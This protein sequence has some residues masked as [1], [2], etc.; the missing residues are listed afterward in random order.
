MIGRPSCL[1]RPIRLVLR[2]LNCTSVRMYEYAKLR[3]GAETRA[4]SQQLWRQIRTVSLSAKMRKSPNPQNYSH[5][6]HTH[7]QASW[8][9]QTYI[10]QICTSQM[11]TH[12]GVYLV[13][14]H[15]TYTGVHVP[16]KRVPY[17]R[18]SHGRV[19]HGCASHRGCT[20]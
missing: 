13:E 18:A 8:T 15:L 19:P 14:V 17:R 11:C 16:H 4:Y 10:S 12:S 20:S 9:L 7:S 2:S 1:F 6:S 5:I 3:I